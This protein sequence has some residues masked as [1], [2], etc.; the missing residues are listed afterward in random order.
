MEN[1]GGDPE[2]GEEVVV[3]QEDDDGDLLISIP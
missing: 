1:L 3:N 2:A